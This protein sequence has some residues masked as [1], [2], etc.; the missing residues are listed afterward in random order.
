VRLELQLPVSFGVV[1]TENVEQAIERSAAGPGNKGAE[2]ARTAIGMVHVL[3][4]L[5]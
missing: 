3:R 4:A 5:R 2:A 1:T